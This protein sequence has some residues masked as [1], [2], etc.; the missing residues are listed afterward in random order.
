[1]KAGWLPIGGRFE[2]RG[3]TV[4]IGALENHGSMDGKFNGTLPWPI[5]GSW[6]YWFEDDV[7]LLERYS[8]RG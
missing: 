5:A 2:G 6:K 4:F 3:R 1:M 8:P 7:G